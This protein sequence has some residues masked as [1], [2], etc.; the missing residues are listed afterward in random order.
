MTWPN[1]T[2]FNGSIGL[3]CH[4]IKYILVSKSS[5]DLLYSDQTSLILRLIWVQYFMTQANINPI[6]KFIVDQL[7]PFSFQP[8]SIKL[9]QPLDSAHHKLFQFTSTSHFIFTITHCHLSLNLLLAIR[10]PVD[11]LISYGNRSL[12]CLASLASSIFDMLHPKI[13]PSSK[14]LNLIL[15]DD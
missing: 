11:I 12:R 3:S 7:D 4:K 14:P 10:F 9:S 8:F 5:L 13:C 15:G 2:C 6:K 1:L